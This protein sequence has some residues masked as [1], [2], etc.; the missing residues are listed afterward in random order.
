MDVVAHFKGARN[1]TT[2][3]T[4]LVLFREGEPG[5]E[6]YVLM[7]GTVEFWVGGD[8]VE[9]AHRAKQPGRRVRPPCRR[10]THSPN[11]RI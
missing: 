1:V 5:K 2:V 7:Q 8:V 10:P 11:Q 6:M 4:G 3:P 9:V